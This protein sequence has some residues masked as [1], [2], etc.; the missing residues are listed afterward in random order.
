M[1]V[2][3]YRAMPKILS[4][5]EK[6]NDLEK[7]KKYIQKTGKIPLAAMEYLGSASSYFNPSKY[8]EILNKELSEIVLNKKEIKKLDILNSSIFEPA[9]IDNY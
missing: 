3:I 5:Q 6:I 8:Y 4:N 1:Q 9:K 2:K 7:Q